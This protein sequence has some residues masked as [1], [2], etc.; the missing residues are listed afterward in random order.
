M[1]NFATRAKVRIPSGCQEMVN[2]FF[3]DGFLFRLGLVNITMSLFWSL[4]CQLRPSRLQ[5]FKSGLWCREKFHP[6]A[7][8][9]TSHICHT[10][11]CISM[12]KLYATAQ[13]IASQ[14]WHS[15][16]QHRPTQMQYKTIISIWHQGFSHRHNTDNISPGRE[17]LQPCYL[18][19]ACQ[20]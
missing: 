4:K 18:V 7:T 6:P 15:I 10:N 2:L 14:R 16:H 12:L 13:I 20:G 5:R 17:S 11:H 9:H 3:S 8:N 1:P 19:P